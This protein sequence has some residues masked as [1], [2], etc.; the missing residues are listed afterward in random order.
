MPAGVLEEEAPAT[1]PPAVPLDP[2]P[3]PPHPE[4]PTKE[5]Q[6]NPP[7]GKP[8]EATPPAE[9]EK[10]PAAVP[11]APEAPDA[12]QTDPP[13]STPE[14]PAPPPVDNDHVAA[15]CEKFASQG[16]PAFGDGE[17]HTDTPEAKTYTLAEFL[18][19]FV[20]S[21]AA[22]EALVVGG[23]EHIP[24]AMCELIGRG[25]IVAEAAAFRHRCW[26]V[27][28]DEKGNMVI[29]AGMNKSYPN[30]IGYLC[31]QQPWNHLGDK[32]VG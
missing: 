7:T 4:E 2:Q 5:A 3:A 32:V 9:P 21:S 25:K 11:S 31:T 12:P 30:K 24:S 8:P 14:Q 20:P 6:E 16:K 29:E 17:S 18:P 28:K 10:A 22:G 19:K 15:G 13:L 27:T 26:T 1:A 23:W